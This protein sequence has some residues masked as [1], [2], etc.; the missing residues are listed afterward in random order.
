MEVLVS[1]RRRMDSSHEIVP[2]GWY[3][4]E[5]RFNPSLQA[6]SMGVAYRITMVSFCSHF[7]TQGL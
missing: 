4:L 6:A 3:N 2:E 1:R 7:A 5:M